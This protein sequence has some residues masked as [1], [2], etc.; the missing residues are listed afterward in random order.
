MFQ[1]FQRRQQHPQ[2]GQQRRGRDVS[3]AHLSP[4]QAHQQFPHHHL[5]WFLGP[6]QLPHH[7]ARHRRHQPPLGDGC[8]AGLLPLLKLKPVAL[9]Q[10][11]IRLDAPRQ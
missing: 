4:A 2:S 7:H 1:Q 9:E 10:F 6:L 5:L 11:E 8:C 3:A